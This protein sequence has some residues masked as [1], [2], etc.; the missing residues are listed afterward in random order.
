MKY[1][2]KLI[3]AGLIGVIIFMRACSP[4]PPPQEPEIITTVDTVKVKVEVPVEVKVPIP[5]KVEVPKEIPAKIDT[6][7]VIQDYFTKRTYEDTV[8]IA[9]M[10][11]VAIHDEIAAN[12]IVV[13]RT[14]GHFTYPK[15]T[16]TTTINNPPKLTNK[17]FVGFQVMAPVIGAGG[18]LT[19]LTKQDAMYQ[20]GG[21]LTP[22]G[23]Y[24][25]FSM[26]WKIKLRK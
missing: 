6:A 17:V 26:S 8:R 11:Y 25:S 21:G 15:I 13:R 5:F 12:R 24:G 9:G 20:V 10:G 7:A 22:Y 19:L 1:L 14:S 23:P 3:I 4:S 18:Q 16:V 2:E